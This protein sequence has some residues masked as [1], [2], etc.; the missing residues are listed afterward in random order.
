MPWLHRRAPRRGELNRG[1]CE[2]ELS[3][4]VVMQRP[5]VSIAELPD[6]QT[7]GKPA[8]NVGRR[9]GRDGSMEGTSGSG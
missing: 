4:S 5:R 3:Q 2:V 1:L 9:D 6:C 8:C 7:T